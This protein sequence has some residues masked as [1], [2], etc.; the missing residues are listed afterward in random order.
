MNQNTFKS[1]RQQLIDRQSSRWQAGFTLIEL[2]V[3]IAI[4][5]ILVSIMLP[6]VQSA[7]EAAQRSK[8]RNNLM[9]LGIAFQNYS[10]TYEMLPPGTINETGPIKTQPDGYH[11]NWVAQMLPVLEQ[12]NLFEAI[13][14]DRSVYEAENS[15]PRSIELSILACP[16]DYNGRYSIEGVGMVQAS[17]YA[18]SY[19]GTK[20]PISRDSDGLL[21][22]NSS[23]RYRQIRDGSSNTILA[24]EK[25]HPRKGDDLGW[26]SGTVAT[27]RNTGIGINLSAD[28]ISEFETPDNELDAGVNPPAKPERITIDSG[29]FS[30]RHPGGAVFL[31]ADGAIR[32][33]S[34]S[35]DRD[36]Y[37]YLGNREDR[38]ILDGF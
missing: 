6:A 15:N 23:I 33:L 38:Q 36:V 17:N 22:L 34:S 18:G 12:R 27:L 4:I 2:L 11:M 10:M 3:V 35:V 16:S 8:C 9:Q 5:A 25:I 30:S 7:R 20:G 31:L 14:F 21:Y 29:G 32:F 24:G 37:R 1:V 26:M 28:V 19:G 13:D